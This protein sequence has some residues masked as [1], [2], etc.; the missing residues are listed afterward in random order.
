MAAPKADITHLIETFYAVA[1][2]PDRWE[3]LIDAVDGAADASPEATAI[4]SRLPGLEDAG[5]SAQP[6]LGVILLSAAGAVVGANL[7]GEMVF[8]DRLGVIESR[9]LKFFN[10]ANHEALTD[11]RRRL[12]DPQARQVI[13][14]FVQA[15]D[16]DPH[17]AY[18][19]EA[20]SAP[21]S[22]VLGLEG[23]DR[24][25]FAIIF[26]ALEAT[27]HLWR[28]LRESFGLTP[29]ETRL[30]ARLKDGMTLKEAA[31]DL[32]VSLN[33][34]RNQLRAVFEKMGLSRQS[35]LVRAL[36]QLGALSSSIQPAQAPTVTASETGALIT[37][38]PLLLHRL[39][40]GR[41]LAYRDYGDP[42]GRP[43]VMFHQGI[44]SS[45]L[46]RGSDALA[47]D[48]GLR[49]VCAER[50]GVGRSDPRSDLSFA[51]VVDD[52][53]HL[54]DSL[55]MGPVRVAAFMYGAP[56]ALAYAAR[57]GPA[58]DRILI[59][60]GR[61][62][63]AASE[64]EEDRTHPMVLLRRRL[65]RT[66]WL[67][68]PLYALLRRRLSRRQVEQMV[69]T[70]A[71]SSSDKA[72]LRSH[73][74]VVDFIHDYMRE[75]LSRSSRGVAR[76]MGLLA[77]TERLDLSGLTAPIHVWHGADDPVG[78]AEDFVAWMG[79]PC[80]EIRAFPGAGH[81]LPHKLWPEVMAW[82][83]ADT[84][85]QAMADSVSAS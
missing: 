18:V 10:P 44:G 85:V 68:E 72:Y 12:A 65:V 49:I 62:T 41:S 24:A 56:F 55:N 73:P 45:L 34:V 16:D 64:A 69:Q 52:V 47:R 20:A 74:G 50:P 63:G 6:E 23:F 8:R 78:S 48:L 82:L 7:A 26:P 46:P 22:L 75:S 37:A 67:A 80:A 38:P 17:F 3:E 60:S 81:F 51:G 58:V 27:D 43:C 1:A 61:R 42:G 4:L 13:V 79:R 76:E 32:G 9:G 54:T 25:A 5:I 71:S 15:R 33:T 2:R 28:S 14:K 66:A 35:D 11:A 53:R 36:A 21:P 83:A 84:D 77:R 19:T 30:A 59:A 31:E 70:A 40:D 57:L 39:P 29:A